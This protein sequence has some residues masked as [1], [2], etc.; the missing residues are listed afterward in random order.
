M[1]T[2]SAIIIG[3]IGLGVGALLAI[4]ISQ[5]PF[6]GLM[7]IIFFLPFERIPTIEVADFTLK[8]NHI[9]GFLLIIFWILDWAFSHKKIKGAGIGGVLLFFFLTLTLSFI[10]TKMPARSAIYLL[11]DIFAMLIFFIASQL[12][13]SKEKLHRVQTALFWG[14]GLAIG[15]GFFQ[16]IGDMIGLP[17][18][19]TGLDPGYSKIVFGFPRIQAFSREPLYFGNYLLLVLGFLLANIGQASSRKKPR[20]FFWLLTA[21]IATIILTASRGALLGLAFFLLAWLFVKKKI[22][23]PKTIT[24]LSALLVIFALGFGLIFSLL[25]KELKDV[26]VGHISLAD[27]SFGEST[28]GRLFAYERAISAFK[29]APLVGIGI[30][31]YGAF[32]ANYDLQSPDIKNIVNNEYI[33][34]LAENGIAGLAGFLM[35]IIYVFWRSA[36][37]IKVAKDDELKNYLI[38]LSLALAAILLQYNFFSTLSVLHIWVAMGV[39]VGVQNIAFAN[40]NHKIQIINQ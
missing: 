10:N 16:F 40:S 23:T 1:F 17:L 8:I 25:G 13:D 35:L 32:T 6:W 37:A 12:I 15:F 33:E 22:I 30:G 14:A 11:L 29:T 5:N 38:A 27:L 31:N 20:A 28:Q 36:L 4:K 34:L 9:L 18:A 2:I 19:I 3:L 24:Y 21:L 26:F 7:A 39:L